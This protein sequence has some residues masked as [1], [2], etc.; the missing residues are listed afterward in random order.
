MVPANIKE[1]YLKAQRMALKEKKELEAAGRDP[2][3]AVLDDIAPEAARLSASELPVQDI[4]ADRIVGVRTR[5]RVS[6]FSASFLP[7]PDID[8]EFAVKW[9]NLLSEQL[10]DTGIRDQIECFEYMGSFYVQE[11]NKRVSVLKH[12]GNTRILSVVY[13]FY[14]LWHN[15]VIS[16]NNKNNNIR[17]LSTTGTHHCK[18]FVSRSIK[19]SD[20]SLSRFNHVCTDMLCDSA[21][22]RCSYVCAADGIKSFG[23]SVVNM[24]HYSNDRRTGL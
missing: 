16:S 22:F 23:L 17:Y 20:S 12:F 19:E 21:E 2:Y 10:S 7:L 8:S 4:P 6:A 3:P 15:T 14:S 5:G 1:E 24:T 11:G 13:R 18:C 9:M